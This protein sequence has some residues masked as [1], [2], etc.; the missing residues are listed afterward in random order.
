VNGAAAARA[1]AG[2]YQVLAG[3]DRQVLHRQRDRGQAA[4]LGEVVAGHHRSRGGGIEQRR[5]DPAVEDASVRA[6]RVGIGQEQLSAFGIPA[7]HLDAAVVVERDALRPV[8]AEPL[9]PL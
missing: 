8:D 3:R 7:H 6:Q 2:R 9:S 4:A 5:H 1:P